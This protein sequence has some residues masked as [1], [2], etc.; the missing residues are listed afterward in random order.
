VEDM[1]IDHEF[2]GI[3]FEWQ[4]KTRQPWVGT[5][6]D[7]TGLTNYYMMTV[8][9]QMLRPSLISA[10]GW[11]WRDIP[12]SYIR[13]KAK[14]FAHMVTELA[15]DDKAQATMIIHQGYKDRMCL[16]AI[17]MVRPETALVFGADSRSRWVGIDKLD[18]VTYWKL[19]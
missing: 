19:N 4:G 15:S 14:A 9:D 1:M 16:A 10:D 17:S 18:N 12:N 5:G 8:R 13:S 2:V 7:C 3:K 11:S 6:L